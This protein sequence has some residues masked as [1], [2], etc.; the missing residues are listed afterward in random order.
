LPPFELFA[1][2]GGCVPIL[3]V[4]QGASDGFVIGDAI[5]RGFGLDAVYHG[6][7]YSSALREPTRYPETSRMTSW[8]TA[9]TST[10][11]SWV[12]SEIRDQ[13]A[14]RSSSLFSFTRP[15]V[16]S[17]IVD[18]TSDTS[19]MEAPIRQVFSTA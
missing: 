16:P 13:P 17:N 1:L 15:L 4:F 5:S 9:S 11:C 18:H 2:F 14:E 10:P 19:S 3:T 8:G 12:L 7:F 6:V